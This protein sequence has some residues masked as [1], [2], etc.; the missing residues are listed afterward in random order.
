MADRDIRRV[1]LTT[2]P[3][4]AELKRVLETEV[5]RALPAG[6]EDAHYP[7]F[8]TVIDLLDELSLPTEHFTGDLADIHVAVAGGRALVDQA[9]KAI[10]ATPKTPYLIAKLKALYDYLAEE[11]KPLPSGMIFVF[12]AKTPLRMEVAIKLYQ[13]GLAPKIMLSGGSPIY[14]EKGNVAEAELYRQL[15]LEAGI[16]DEAMIVEEHSITIPD[17]VR[18]SL[19]LLDELKL[20]PKSI[21]L[22][23]SPYTQRRGW[24]LFRKH[25]SDDVS[26]YRV[27]C[28]TKPEF[29]REH[30]FEQEN[31]LRVLLNEFI[32]MRASVV[33]N[34]A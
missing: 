25:V 24:A 4:A 7:E 18:R 19:N 15:G 11:D 29:T 17:N 9:A 34:T 16:P 32:K 5:H 13:D 10:L 2:L 1:D 8:D 20:S 30:W 3:E 23:S 14:A 12:G 27:N 26:F 22:V 21:I 31:T 6:K 28:G 33:Y